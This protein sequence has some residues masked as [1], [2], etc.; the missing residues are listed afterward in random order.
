MLLAL[1]TSTLLLTG[2][3]AAEPISIGSVST[4]TNIAHED[5]VVNAVERVISEIEDGGSTVVL[6]RSDLLEAVKKEIVRTGA[7]TGPERDVFFSTLERM[8]LDSAILI[9]RSLAIGDNA[10][11]AN[12]VSYEAW[13]N[14]EDSE[15]R[16]VT[17]ACG[18]KPKRRTKMRVISA[19]NE[20]GW[21]IE[22]KR[23][24]VHVPVPCKD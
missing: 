16:F 23:T 8:T 18:M 21:D 10:F 17:D 7:I 15:W 11:A 5:A 9:F 24:I 12:N 19:D 2:L 6:E 4:R 1:F 20:R 13:D 14:L 22:L 3:A